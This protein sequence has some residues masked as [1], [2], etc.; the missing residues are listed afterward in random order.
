ML[1]VSKIILE[2]IEDVSKAIK[3][4]SQK[5]LKKYLIPKLRDE[6]YCF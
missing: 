3:R 2:L 1:P 5:H 4:L 6:I